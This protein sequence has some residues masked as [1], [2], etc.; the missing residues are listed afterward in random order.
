[1]VSVV[2]PTYNRAGTLARSIDSVLAQTYTNFELI[3]VDDGSTDDTAG[4]LRNYASDARVRVLMRGHLGCASARN[5]GVRA[6]AAPYVAFQ[7]SDDEWFPHKLA[8]A[9]DA[10]KHTGPEVGVFYSDMLWIRRSGSVPFVSPDVKRGVLIDPNTLDFAVHKVGVQS[11]L[12]KRAC[13]ERV[14]LFDEALSRLIDLE[15]FVRLSALY[16][17]VHHREPLVRFG[18]SGGISA[19]S[20]ALLA[21]RLYLLAKYG[22]QLKARPE[23]LAMQH[24]L[25]AGAAL[26]C[27]D[28]QAA[29][30]AI[31]S[32]GR[33]AS[34]PT[35]DRAARRV[36]AALNADGVAFDK[37]G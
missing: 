33:F 18:E 13:F 30:A 24:V 1:M 35:V 26:E 27:G 28:R 3:V 5:A 19:D 4:V 31:E 16:E 9:I 8:V 7:D 22:R 32:A 6:A 15:L 17:F 23:H 20:C 34:H 14:G 37:A 11:A 25:I 21:A 12:V 36:V 10:L 29:A 2:L